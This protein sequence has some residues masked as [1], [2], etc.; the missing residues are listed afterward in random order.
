MQEALPYKSWHLFPTNTTTLNKSSSLKNQES[1]GDI[2]NMVTENAV[3][4]FGRRGC[5]MSHVI[6][7]LLQC[8][9]VNPF[10][11]DIEEK[12]ENEVVAELEDIDKKTGGDRKDGRSLQ[13]PAVFIGGELFGGLDRIMAAH[14]TGELSP[15]LKQAGALWL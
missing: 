13:L 7:R 3:I 14:I 6:K 2:K 11:Y 10:I 4:V 15:I 9:G 8:L 5:C 12:Y 1:K